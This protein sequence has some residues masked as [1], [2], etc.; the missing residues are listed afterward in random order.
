MKQLSP[1]KITGFISTLV[2]LFYILGIG[3]LFFVGLALV[4][5]G[6]VLFLMD[7]LSKKAKSKRVYWLIQF[8][9][10]SPFLVYI[11]HLHLEGYKH[12]LI[13]FPDDF[14]GESGLIFGIEGYPELPGM[15]SWK[16]TIEIPESGVL[17]TS[18][19]KEHLPNGFK[20]QFR[21]GT[22]LNFNDSSWIWS[23]P[24]DYPCI[25]TASE[26]NHFYFRIG[27][28]SE[29]N[30]Q[31]TLSY[32]CDSINQGLLT[33]LYKTE[34]SPVVTSVKKP[35]LNLQGW[36]ISTLPDRINILDVNRIIL[37]D[38][39]FS[40]F[41][42]EIMDMPQLE[43][44]LI[45]HNPVSALPDDL[46]KLG[47]LVYL[48]LNNTLVRDFPTDLSAF[49]N[50][51]TIGLDHNELETVPDPILTIPKLKNLRLN[52]N[53]LTD[54]TFID[55]RL[56]QLESISVYSN[57][58]DQIDCNI[59][60][61]TGLTELLI[62]DNE[63]D[64]IPDCISSLVNLQKL[65]IWSN[66]ITFVTPEVEKLKNLKTLRMDSEHLTEQ[67]MQNIRQWLPKCEII[68]Q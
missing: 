13:V 19:L 10:S 22:T 58:I 26:I 63:I 25:L 3:Y 64:S 43:E 52:N 65:E 66:P 18:T 9:I 7:W 44:L 23:I 51:E 60:F 35:Y 24:R 39:N 42:K 49:E 56:D 57:R 46:S 30:F 15:K 28:T 61:L 4:G 8:F 68:F 1:L 37:T 33:S 6:I 29:S 67:Q 40:A 34:F 5:S 20:F 45:G 2:G 12:N 50:L 62:F 38:N 55:E 31:E 27:N 41:P 47:N 59:M 53:E 36:N 48:S 21:D 17:I 11:T 54:L 16:R 14:K 32:L